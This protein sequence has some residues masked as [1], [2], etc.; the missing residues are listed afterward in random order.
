MG[1][2]M[3]ESAH[4]L[5]AGENPT[6]GEHAVVASAHRTSQGQ[7]LRGKLSRFLLTREVKSVLDSLALGEKIRANIV[8]QFRGAGIIYMINKVTLG[9]GSTWKDISLPSMLAFET[10]EASASVI[11]VR[12]DAAL[13][14][15]KTKAAF[16]AAASEL[17]CEVTT[18]VVIIL[19]GVNVYAYRLLK[20]DDEVGTLAIIAPQRSVARLIP[21]YEILSAKEVALVGC[22]SLGS[23]IATMLARS[24]VDNFLL[25][26]DDILLPDNFVRNDLDW[27][28]VGL[29]KA[30]AVASKLQLVRPS[31]QTRVRRLQLGGQESATSADT[32]LTALAGCD[33]VIDA[34]ANPAALNVISGI[35]G[36][37]KKPVLWAEVFA[38][39]FGG[40]IAR[41]RPGIEPSIPVMRCA[42]ENWFAERDTPSI[43]GSV[44]YDQSG[45]GLPFIADDADVTAI[46][47]PAARLA[48]DCL[49]ERKPSYFPYSVYLIGL[50]PG[51]V[52]AQPFETYPIDLSGAPDEPVSQPLEQDQAVAEIT[53][54]AGLFQR[55]TNEDT[56][57][58]PGD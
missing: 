39:G 35:M 18:D 8:L 53:M 6:P 49:L 23:K 46:A 57:P 32:V 44:G 15:I 58:L 41:C 2:Q 29:H 38:G 30:D 50:S 13:P 33:L 40:F 12:D 34:T 1:F 17:D 55:K 36:S 25:I 3:L 42:I 14:P 4:R 9:D 5:L 19:R 27:R 28:D 31:A 24:G 52:F 21:D 51:P 22:G 54:I 48:L 37:A 56:S 16:V 20:S 11:R 7:D 47:S 43:R 26:D 10:F 45:D